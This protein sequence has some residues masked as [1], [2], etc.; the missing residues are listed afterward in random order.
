[1]FPNLLK[2]QTILSDATSKDLQLNEKLG[3]LLEIS[4]KENTSSGGHQA[5]YLQA[6]H[7]FYQH[8]KRD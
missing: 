7:R 4:K 5:Y 8:L 1:M 2:M 3:T 6:T